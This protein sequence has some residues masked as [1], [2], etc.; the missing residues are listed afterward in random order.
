MS[1]QAKRLHSYGGLQVK[2]LTILPE[3]K[4]S[5]VVLGSLMRIIT[6]AKRCREG[7]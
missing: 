2:P 3:A 6:A 4:M 5:A 1:R 7:M